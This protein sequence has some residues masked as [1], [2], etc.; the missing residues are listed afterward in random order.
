MYGLIE[1]CKKGV[2]I[3]FIVPY[4]ERVDLTEMAKSF[5]MSLE[6]IESAVANLIVEG[7]VKG[8][9]DSY[10]KV[11]HKVDDNYSFKS[12]GKALTAGDEFLKNVELLLNKYH[13]DP[14]LSNAE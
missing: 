9:I 3:M 5:G 8:R 4:K 13:L 12:F 10:N 7:D 6:D 1:T 2:M 11:L 14:K